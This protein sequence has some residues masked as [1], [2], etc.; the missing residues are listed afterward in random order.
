MIR[1]LI[2]CLMA[3]FLLGQTLNVIA[4]DSRRALNQ[5]A[6]QQWQSNSG[7]P[8]DSLHAILQSTDG[9]IWL[10]T[11]GGLVRFNGINFRI[12]N[13][14]N[15][16]EIRSNIVRGLAQDQNGTL[17]ISTANGLLNYRDHHFHIFGTVQ[18]LPSDVVWF[19]HQ[20]HA[21]GLWAGTSAGL[22]LLS[23]DRWRPI[24]D[25]AGLH[26]EMEKQIADAPDGSIWLSG[27][28]QLIHLD[29]RSLRVLG[30]LRV[31]SASEIN[32]I[33]CD[34]AGSLWVGTQ[35][36]LEVYAQGRVKPISF[37][38]STHNLQ[39]NTIL[40]TTAN[41]A[42]VGTSRGLYLVTVSETVSFKAIPGLAEGPVKTLLLDREGALWG[43]TDRGIARL[44]QNHV[45]TISIG[46]D[47]P[48]STIDALLEDR[49]GNLWIGGEAEGLAVLRDQKFISFTKRDGLSANTIT[50]ISGD[51]N[52]TLWIG[53]DGAGLNRMGAAGVTTYS[54]ANGLSSNVILASA[55]DQHGDTWVGTSTGLNR[56]HNGRVRVYTVADGLIDDFVRSLF[57]DL[58]DSLWVG[59]RHGL[60][61]MSGEH[62]IDYSKFD[63]LGSDFVGAI[64]R[65][66]DGRLWVGTSGGLSLYHNGSFTTFT[67]RDGLSSNT[68]TAIYEDADGNLWL[69]TNGGGLN[70]LSGDNIQ[71]FRNGPPPVIYGILEDSANDLWLSSPSGVYRVNR[72]ALNAAIDHSSPNQL[73]IAAFGTGDGMKTRECSGSGH[74][75][76]WKQPD[77]SLWFAT[78]HGVVS[79][80]PDHLSQNLV[81][82]QT[83]VESVLVDDSLSDI[84]GILTLGPGRH[85][86]EFQYAGLSFVMPQLVTYRYRLQGYDRDWISG[87]HTHSAF[88]TNLPPG[89]YT[90][91][92]LS[93]NNDGVWAKSPA[94]ISLQIKPYFY[95]TVWFYVVLGLST[96]ILARLIYRW[97]LRRVETEFGAV[98]AERNRIAREIHD[99]LAQDIVS[100]SL[101]LEVISRLLGGPAQAV[102][103]QLD[104]T[105]ELVKRSLVEARRS[106]WALRSQDQHGDLPTRLAMQLRE[107]SQGV[108][109]RVRLEVQGSTRA[110]DRKIE[111][112]LLSIS[113]EAVGNA[114]RHA[115][116]G[117]IDVK[118]LYDAETI[119]LRIEDDGQGFDIAR[120]PDHREGYFGLQGMR[121]RA[122]EIRAGFQ[123]ESKQSQGTKVCV[124]LRI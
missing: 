59:T 86:V 66:R 113:K 67:V 37:G 48:G 81:P 23:G 90:F 77:G 83:M 106:I 39:I 51:R 28:N 31:T 30:R 21:G 49:E 22:A 32:S 107:V 36:G 121:E 79:V 3:T 88:Y 44:Q 4:L 62:F 123:I 115:E 16:S 11:D 91:Q 43:G 29:S 94:Q 71:S 6:Y 80:M 27:G 124:E 76:A 95:Q 104:Q 68:I 69:G 17:W 34:P 64:L 54:T 105:R 14:E 12:F 57:V 2:S 58:D 40:P 55:T 85:R 108:S 101:Q 26:P 111:D 56:I 33:A 63:G 84:S 73:Q 119:C 9:Y 65:A 74:P 96:L 122:A 13:T 117:Q 103:E 60:A 38:A 5:Y 10:A 97:N 50:S 109:T 35:Q 116:A 100:I 61:H 53:T 25:T 8:Q 18:G 72:I 42:W 89:R 24:A 20:D 1:T 112:E 93:A 7:L 98:L 45:D 78:M 114:L 15:T 102:R 99:T 110:I 41:R 70:R 120:V 46:S 82:P 19:V 118:L 47:L 92:V 52:G 75:E 87:G